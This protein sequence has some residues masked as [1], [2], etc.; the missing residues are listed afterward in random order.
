MSRSGLPITSFPTKDLEAQVNIQVNGKQRKKPV[1]LIK[2]CP[3]SQFFQYEC[4]ERARMVARG[5]VVREIKCVPKLR[6]F[7]R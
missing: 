1:D 2:D 3:V 5:E 6:M 7:R 4:D